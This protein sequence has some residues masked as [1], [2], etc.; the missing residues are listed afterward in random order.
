MGVTIGTFTPI[1]GSG[2]IDFGYSFV[3][4]NASDFS[5]INQGTA[6]LSTT[7]AGILLAKSGVAG[8]NWRIQIRSAPATPYYIVGAFMGMITT[9]NHNRMGFCWRESATQELVGASLKN[10]NWQIVKMTSPTVFVSEA[11]MANL[12]WTSNLGQPWWFQAVDNGVNREFWVSGDGLSWQ[13]GY[14]ETRTTFLTAD[15]IGFF[16]DPN[17]A[18]YGCACH[19]MS[20]QS[21][22]SFQGVSVTT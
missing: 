8:D 3:R 20:W 6:T 21:Y 22:T 4:P 12:G 18:N 5:W 1:A 17:N 15:Q 10:Q 2:G 13:R 7:P 19:L 9:V 16:V 11:T 14:Q